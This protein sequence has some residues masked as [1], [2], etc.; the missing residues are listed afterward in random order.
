MISL[1][2]CH[3]LATVSGR[4]CQANVTDHHYNRVQQRNTR[5]SLFYSALQNFKLQKWRFLLR[6]L[7]MSM[8]MSWIF[9]MERD[10]IFWR[11]VSIRCVKIEHY[12]DALSSM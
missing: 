4:S 12:G 6:I 7:N 11:V 8:T 9:Q 5:V 1:K 3:C 2:H 10:Q